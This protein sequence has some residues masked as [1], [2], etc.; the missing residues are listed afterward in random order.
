MSVHVQVRQDFM[1]VV[2]L[3][4]LDQGPEVV[5]LRCQLL[6]WMSKQPIHISTNQRT[7]RVTNGHAI[8]V[9]HRYDFEDDSLSE[10]VGH[11]VLAHKKLDD[12]VH[13][14]RGIGLSWMYTSCNYDDPFA[15][16][17]STS[18]AEV[19]DGDHGHF[20]PGE[21]GGEA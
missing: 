2:L 8:C 19:S 17:L 18:L 7:S 10:F 4:I 12:S 21:C 9:D 14:P 6:I 5:R 11:F 3:E 15:Q 20:H 16:F 13:N 1:L